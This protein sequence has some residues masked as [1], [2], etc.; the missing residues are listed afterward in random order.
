MVTQHRKKMIRRKQASSAR[1]MGTKWK[2]SRK[3][4]DILVTGVEASTLSKTEKSMSRGL[5]GSDNPKYLQVI[6]NKVLVE[7]EPMVPT[8]DAGSG[9]T[10]EVCDALASGKLVLADES[11]FAL[12]KY[13]YK[14]TVLS[15]GERC[16]H[17]KVGD[18]IQ[19]AHLGVQRFP[20]EGKQYLIMHEDDVHGNYAL[21][22]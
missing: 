16:K 2:Q 17:V 7:E 22:D 19:F 12:I 20:F 14:G 21:L 6:G 11:E 5:K 10:Q 4:T 9:L 3:A 15:V 18:R 13:P 8:P 1:M